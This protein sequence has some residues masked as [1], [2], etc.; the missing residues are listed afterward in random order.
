MHGRRARARTKAGVRASGLACVP[1]AFLS[2]LLAYAL[3]F[4][5]VLAS[6]LMAAQTATA[7]DAGILC[8]A[9]ASSGD[10]QQG[11]DGAE[12]GPQA[13]ILHCPLCLSRVEAVVLPP[14]AP[15]LHI[16]RRATPLRF[17][18]GRALRVHIPAERPAFRPRDPPVRPA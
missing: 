7:S 6:G 13:A 2:L 14:P 11:T 1:S 17:A 3:V 18:A 15:I 12:D 10:I 9:S 16:E 4:Q 5:V 8:L